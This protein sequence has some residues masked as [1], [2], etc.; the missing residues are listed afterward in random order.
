[1]EITLVAPKLVIFSL[2]LCDFV[3]ENFIVLLYYQ[4]FKPSYH[5]HVL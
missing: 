2:K 1:M 5:K 3:T 4:I